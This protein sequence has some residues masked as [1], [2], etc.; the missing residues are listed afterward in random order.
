[1]LVREIEFTAKIFGPPDFI[2][3]FADPWWSSNEVIEAIRQR[4]DH[5]RTRL[6]SILAGVLFDQLSDPDLF[7][8]SIA[9]LSPCIIAL[10]DWRQTVAQV[11]LTFLLPFLEHRDMKISDLATR[12]GGEIVFYCSEVKEPYHRFM[13]EA[14][15]LH[16]N[17]IEESEYTD[18][19]CAWIFFHTF[20]HK[21]KGSLF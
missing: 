8:S 14:A 7:H 17:A 10:P 9:I 6:D 20:W 16:M 1:L 19:V 15:V 11:L 21:D 2:D 4:P 5:L 3:T 12:L 18:K 13:R